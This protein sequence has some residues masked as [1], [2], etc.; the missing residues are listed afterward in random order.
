MHITDAVSDIPTEANKPAVLTLDGS[1]YCRSANPGLHQL[2]VSYSGTPKEG[3]L[4]IEVQ[5]QEHLD[6]ILPARHYYVTAGGL[7]VFRWNE[8]PL[9]WSFNQNLIVTL[10]AGG[11]G[12]KGSISAI[13][14]P[15]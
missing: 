10:C 5:D 11:A 6:R 2:E 13:L 8:S 7:T 1:F 3:A 14:L 15:K 4:K 9:I 12:V